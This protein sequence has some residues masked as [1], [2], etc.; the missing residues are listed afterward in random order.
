MKRHQRL[1]NGPGVTVNGVESPGVESPPKRA[2]TQISSDT[3]FSDVCIDQSTY[4]TSVSGVSPPE[5][6][7]T[8]TQDALPSLE[9][10]GLPG[11]MSPT[12][13]ILADS[14][15][16]NSFME[17]DFGFFEAW[18][19]A[20]IQ[21]SAFTSGAVPLTGQEDA[22]G[23]AFA[24]AAP[25][26]PN[27]PS[28][29]DRTAFAWNPRSKRISEIGEIV[30][31]CEDPLLRDTNDRFVP[32]EDTYERLRSTYDR[33][34]T[35]AGVVMANAVPFFPA[36]PVI[37][38]LL[39]RFA[40]CF[41]PQ[42]PVLHLPTF[43]V[44]GCPHYLLA[45]F[46]AIGA[47]Y[48]RRGHMR[49]FAI[50]LQDAARCHLKVAVDTDDTLLR[51]PLTIYAASLICYAGLWCGNKRAF[52]LADALRGNVVVWM[53]R[54]PSHNEPKCLD[55]KTLDRGLHETWTDW[56]KHE[57]LTRLRW[58]TYILDC[59]FSSLM[60]VLPSMAITETL[61]WNCPCDDEYWTA[62]SARC[63]QLLLGNAGVPPSISFA[64]AIAPFLDIDTHLR[65][66]PNLNSFSTFIVLL[67]INMDI[68][69]Y[70]DRRELCSEVSQIVMPDVTDSYNE[71]RQEKE[72]LT[73][74]Q[75][76]FGQ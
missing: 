57:S 2:R 48:C 18:I 68:L 67:S 15:S 38:A 11:W 66:L 72:L 22:H 53:R 42:W 74:G 31:S 28:H 29:E 6:L 59:Q 62:T 65:P 19:D 39:A 50:V 23:T 44:N 49:R 37:D 8:A 21:D 73:Q 47:T 33:P 13:G 34:K 63:C 4:Y 17:P 7:H 52:E 40:R 26:P 25:S 60:S 1:H 9:G 36:A 76:L 24:S 61:S 64:A 20:P 10:S 3:P 46:V 54:M 35:T 71:L 41:L 27:E 69:R 70:A 45:A 55:S 5:P 56:A 51:D 43:N 16:W 12:D 75:R 32:R 30:L 58:M 14:P